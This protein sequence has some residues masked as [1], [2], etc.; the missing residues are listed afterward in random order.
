MLSSKILK[1]MQ[2]I[3]DSQKIIQKMSTNEIEQFLSC[4]PVGSLGVIHN[5]NPY[6]VP[7]GF[8]YSNGEIF[9]HTCYSGLKMDC[10]KK[11]PNVCFEVNESLTDCSMFKSVIIFGKA[12]IIKEEDEMIPY[13]QKLIDKYRV[14]VEF[15]E[16]IN[17]S[18]RDREKE[19]NIVRIVK[20]VPEEITNR[21]IIRSSTDPNFV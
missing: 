6:V 11:N 14:P 8:G 13:L 2:T 15:E 18:G 10:I 1:E 4:A 12:E 7:L 20:I 3:K 19:M 17:R 9:F 21:K 16:Y 5:G